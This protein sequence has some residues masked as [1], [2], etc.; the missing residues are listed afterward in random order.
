MLF[1]LFYST[2]SSEESFSKLPDN[3]HKIT[4][5][6][7]PSKVPSNLLGANLLMKMLWNNS[8][9]IQEYT[10]KQS[11]TEPAARNFFRT[12]GNP[13]ELLVT[14]PH[15]CDKINQLAYKKNKCLII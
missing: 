1:A 14:S 13:R 4:P 8:K 11:F 12:Q 6:H 10:H 3:A 9:R 2:S 5:H 7:T 15:K